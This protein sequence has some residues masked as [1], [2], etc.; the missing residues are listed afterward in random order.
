[1]YIFLVKVLMLAA[2]GCSNER[3]FKKIFQIIGAL[4]GKI[5][6]QRITRWEFKL[7]TYCGYNMSLVLVSQNSFILRPTVEDLPIYYK[8]YISTG[9]QL[10]LIIITG[11]RS[12]IIQGRPPV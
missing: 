12:F 7:K 6:F 4:V 8:Y 11:S 2:A 1:M 10:P 5:I 9:L 3:N